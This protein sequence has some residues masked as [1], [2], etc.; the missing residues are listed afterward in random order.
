[1]D[2]AM[3]AISSSPWIIV[4]PNFGSSRFKYSITSDC[5]VMG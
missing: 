1:M 5:G 2:I 4:P 3:D